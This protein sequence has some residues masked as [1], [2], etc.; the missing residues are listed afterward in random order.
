VK[1]NPERILILRLSSIGD[2]VLSSFFIR[3]VA[4]S[5]PNA[6][7]DFVIKREYSDLIRYNP[8]LNKSYYIVSEKGYAQLYQLRNELKSKYYDFVFDL[9][10]N[11]RT[12][13][14]LTGLSKSK[15]WK[16]NKNKIL[17]ALFVWFK[18]NS[19]K[20]IKPIPIRYLQ[21][22]KAV[23]INDDQKGLELFW[24]KMIEHE[25]YKKIPALRKEGYIALAPGA[26]HYTKKWPIEYY[27]ELVNTIAE[28]RDEKIII[29][30]GSTDM[31][32]GKELELNKNV[33]N[34]TGMLSLLESAIVIK[35][36]KTLISN[37]S[38]AMHIATAVKTPVITIFGSTVEELGFFP[39]RSRH[40][41]I[42][43]EGLKCRP[44]SH[45]GK[46][47]CPK[48]HFRCMLDIKPEFVF[49]ELI[50]LVGI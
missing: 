34:L 5:F 42:Q 23:G 38:G 25:L 43:N 2:I 29:L 31:D 11:L 26:A 30:G 17:R 45:I 37:D 15:K 32:D 7:I 35:N 4:N 33:I 14:L 46:E 9:H 21:T 39:F 36:A 6:K 22:G 49:N 12:K 16:I 19:Y 1:L 47:Y 48:G 20:K 50:N 18:I 28:K 13:F 10:D 8:Y 44:C 27:M 3:Q 24:D 41:V 40:C